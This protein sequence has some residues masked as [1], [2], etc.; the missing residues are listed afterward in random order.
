MAIRIVKVY[1]RTGDAG[2]T[3]LVGGARV[4][5]DSLRIESYG[6]VDEL[7]A[8]V[9]MVRALNLAQKNKGIVE[10]IENELQF[11]QQSLF[12]L[13]SELACDPD[14]LIEG[15]PRVST[16]DIAALERSMDEW[17]AELPPLNSFILPGGGPVHAQLHVARTVCRRT[18]RIVLAL[19]REETVRPEAIGYLNRLSD[20]FFVLGRW[21][22][23]QY[24]E[25]EFLWQSGLKRGP[26][27]A[28]RAAAKS[29]KSAR[30]A[31]STKVVKATKPILTGKSSKSPKPSATTRKPKK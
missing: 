6:T 30:P 4:R 29:A 19:S 8:T 31:K 14:E 10:R 12:D 25:P 24:G 1:T 17:T 21:V 18:E 7:N 11:V 16:D 13:G 20:Y 22:G 26:S 9:G 27:K 23:K 3:S 15:M 5:K 2:E 28:A